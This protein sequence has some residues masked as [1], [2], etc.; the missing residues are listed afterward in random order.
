[1]RLTSR[2]AKCRHVL[3]IPFALAVLASSP[4]FAQTEVIIRDAPP[5]MR[6]EPMPHGRP[7]YVWDQGHWRNDG[8]GYVWVPGHWQPEQRGAR[9]AP[10]HWVARGPNWFWVEG[11]WK[12]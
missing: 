8:R 1:M 12:R 3:I 9:W 7:G 10:G 11:H 4:A 5:P 6:V 2:L